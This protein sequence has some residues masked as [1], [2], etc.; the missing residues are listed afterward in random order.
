MNEL[1]IVGILA[2]CLVA[3]GV[4][5]LLIAVHLKVR[6]EKRGQAR[7]AEESRE[8]AVHADLRELVG[9]LNE[10]SEGIEQRLQVR[11]KE[12]RELLSQ[13][14]G[15]VNEG[16]TEGSDPVGSEAGDR[17][18]EPPLQTDTATPEVTDRTGVAATHREIIR[19]KDQGVDPVEIARRVQMNVGVVE[20]VLNLYPSRGAVEES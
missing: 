5:L 2:G 17:L 7:R 12:L 13:V 1:E 10:V 14:D 15:S 3:S 18:P 20:L 16:R 9:R 6:I 19:L 4:F 8:L 11:M